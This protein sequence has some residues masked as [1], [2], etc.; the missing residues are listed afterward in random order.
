MEISVKVG[1]DRVWEA[2]T[3]PSVL[4]RWFGW[5]YDGLDAE[6]KHIF[7]D[8]AAF[9]APERMGW[10][11]GSYLEV[12]G[13][14]DNAAIR[15]VREGKPAAASDR[16]CAIEEGW[17][18]FLIQL[19]Y[20]LEEQPQG[21]RRTIYLTGTATGRQTLKMAGGT[22]TRVGRRVAWLVDS[23]GHL[24]VVAGRQELDCA[25]TGYQEVV[26]ST[27]GLDDSAFEVVRKRWTERWKPLAGEARV[28]T[29]T[30]P[31]P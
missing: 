2:V 24:V 18:S 27:Y 22:P 26:I 6:I 13:D 4:R 1:R 14:D 8:E 28:T 19:R 17:R 21:A 23:D 12:T 15:A 31:A 5:D 11:D 29:A 10:A 30:D 16:Y 20:L 7:V 3:Q 25:A 9:R